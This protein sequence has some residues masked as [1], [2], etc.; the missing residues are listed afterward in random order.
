MTR[1]QPPDT[2]VAWIA[3]G[4]LRNVAGALYHAPALARRITRLYIMGGNLMRSEFG[5]APMAR[6]PHSC[7]RCPTCRELS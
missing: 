2:K 3:Q 1:A 6:R 4:S 7:W 5:S